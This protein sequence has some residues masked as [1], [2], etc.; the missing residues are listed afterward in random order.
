MSTNHKARLRATQTGPS[1]SSAARSQM[2]LGSLAATSAPACIHEIFVP[3]HALRIVRSEENDKRS[4]VF[5]HQA[6]IDALRVDDLGFALGRV[7]LLLSR[8]L[9]IAGHDAVY[10]NVVRPQVAGERAGKP[11]NRRFARLVKD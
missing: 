11:F 2:F 9:H 4:D 10:A 7:P 5:R 8:R 3:G 6:V 1:P